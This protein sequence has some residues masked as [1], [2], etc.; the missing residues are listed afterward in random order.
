MF[1]NT[2]QAATQEVILIA[3]FS[4]TLLTLMLFMSP[5][6]PPFPS[7]NKH[8][9]ARTEWKGLALMEKGGSQKY[10]QINS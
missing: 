8:T 2:Y 9:S 4:W 3:G 10:N 5:V 7:T 6:Q 1:Q